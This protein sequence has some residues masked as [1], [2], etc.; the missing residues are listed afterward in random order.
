MEAESTTC[1]GGES[2]TVWGAPLLGERQRNRRTEEQK[3]GIEAYWQCKVMSE[4]LYLALPLFP[5]IYVPPEHQ[6]PSR[7]AQKGDDPVLEPSRAE[8]IQA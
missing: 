7:S 3:D 2:P 5:K 1:S 4:D 8:R 6:Q